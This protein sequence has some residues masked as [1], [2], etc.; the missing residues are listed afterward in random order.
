MKFCGNCGNKNSE[1]DAFCSKCGS[2]IK[3]GTKEIILTQKKKK[4]KPN[5][6]L[7]LVGLIFLGFVLAIIN[8]QSD[9]RDKIESS[10]KN[11]S[12]SSSKNS[13]SSYPNGVSSA[14]FC[15][16]ALSGGNNYKPTAKQVTQCRTM[17]KCWGNAKADCLSGS[18]N[19]WT[20]CEN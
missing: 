13:Q 15:M 10:F 11:T 20:R 18:S 3:T 2:K 12:N 19:V 8:P 16:D 17:Y 5:V 7:F 9:L 6:F 4:A 14:C 1:N